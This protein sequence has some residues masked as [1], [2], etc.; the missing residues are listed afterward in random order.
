VAVRIPLRVLVARVDDLR[1]LVVGEDLH[2]D[3]LVGQLPRLER[4][5]LILLDPAGLLAE[6][7]ER[8]EAFEVFVRRER[9]IRPRRP[10]LPQRVDVQLLEVPKAFLLAP[11][12]EALLEEVL[13]FADRR[14][15]ELPRGGVLE[16]FLH[17]VGDGRGVGADDADL[18]AR[19][20][21]RDQFRGSFPGASALR[22][23]SP[24]SDPST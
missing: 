22:T 19:H 11:R 6:A 16:E 17:R 9:A 4:F 24:P 13:L 1:D 12:D 15:L 2:L 23:V 8:A 7:L 10:E 18:A 5:R 21:A 20:P 3:R 14:R